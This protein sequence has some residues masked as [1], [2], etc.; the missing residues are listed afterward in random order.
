[1]PCPVAG[2]KQNRQ[3]AER[4]GPDRDAAEE[5]EDG[6]GCHQKSRQSITVGAKLPGAVPT[7]KWTSGQAERP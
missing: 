4:H 3:D 7:L 1:V 2:G 5:A 6:N